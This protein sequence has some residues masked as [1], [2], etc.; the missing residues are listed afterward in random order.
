MF[1]Q[2]SEPDDEAAA[3]A[4]ARISNNLQVPSSLAE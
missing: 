3:V 1:E 2:E 4:A